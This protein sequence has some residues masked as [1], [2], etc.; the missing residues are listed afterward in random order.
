MGYNGSNRR[1]LPRKGS[2]FSKSSMR[3]G[4]RMFSKTVIGGLNIFGCVLGA[5]SKSTENSTR[6]RPQKI[7]VP[8]GEKRRLD[9]EKTFDV[10][11]FDQPLNLLTKEKSDLLIK[12]IESYYKSGKL[13]N[14]KFILE[15]IIKNGFHKTKC[16]KKLLK[17]YLK[18][19]N[20]DNS[21]TYWKFYVSE[22]TKECVSKSGIS[23]IDPTQISN[24]MINDMMK[25]EFKDIEFYLPINIWSTEL[26]HAIYKFS[27]IRSLREKLV[28][29]Q[30]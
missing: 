11:D 10:F 20:Y 29:I 13:K 2:G 21:L 7:Y 19:G 9:Y 4:T 24:D 23:E 30:Q 5:L 17:M 26:I 16:Y 8:L 27:N 14:Y 28:C 15:S 25:D 22:L 3:F 1:G 12:G 18:T 6:Y